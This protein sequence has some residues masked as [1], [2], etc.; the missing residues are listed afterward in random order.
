MFHDPEMKRAN[1]LFFFCAELVEPSTFE[2][3]P[4]ESHAEQFLIRQRKFIWCGLEGEG[5]C[6]K[7]VT[8]TTI[9]R[10]RI[11]IADLLKTCCFESFRSQWLRWNLFTGKFTGFLPGLMRFYWVFLGC[12]RPWLGFT[13]FYRVSLGYT[14][15]YLITLGLTGFYLFLLGFNWV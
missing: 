7:W 11:V 13:R 6:E 8:V 9:R 1:F 2:S 3:G 15:F 14:G 10:H 4:D 5:D 12:T